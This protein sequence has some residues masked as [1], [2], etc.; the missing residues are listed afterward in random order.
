[1]AGKPDIQ[2]VSGGSPNE[3]RGLASARLA[4]NIDAR[5]SDALVL[6][7]GASGRIIVAGIGKSGHVARK[8]AATLASTGSPAQFV[9]PAE[10]SHGDLGMI[11]DKADCDH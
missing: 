8:I 5:L 7:Q 11:T 3:D 1:M 9:H 6:L 2:T 10:A 4:E